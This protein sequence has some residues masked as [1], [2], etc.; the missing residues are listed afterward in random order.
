MC[1]RS[2]IICQNRR[3][4]RRVGPHSLLN[5][6]IINKRFHTEIFHAIAPCTI[7]VT[8]LH[9]T[10]HFFCYHSGCQVLWPPTFAQTSIVSS[11]V[12]PLVNQKIPRLASVVSSQIG[13][14]P[15]ELIGR[16]NSRHYH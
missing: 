4:P 12:S 5:I 15:G 10:S 13:F 7:P 8:F 11:E 14:V 2:W 9:L 3:P 6:N 1:I 16:T